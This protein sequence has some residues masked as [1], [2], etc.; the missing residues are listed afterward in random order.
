MQTHVV[1]GS[2][3]LPLTA[4]LLTSC[5]DKKTAQAAPSLPPALPVQVQ[6]V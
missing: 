1:S 3:F 2:V 6:T 5:G 4:L